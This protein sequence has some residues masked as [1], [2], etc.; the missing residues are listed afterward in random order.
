MLATW[1]YLRGQ[2]AVFDRQLLAIAKARSECRLLM[3]IPG[4]GYVSALAFIGA[5]DAPDR[6]ARSRSVGAH[7]GLV[8]KQHQSGDVDRLGEISKCGDAYVRTVLV[9][10]ANS[11]LIR[12]R[13]PS[14]L[15]EWGLALERRSGPKKA[16]TAL[17]RKLAVVMHSVWRSGTPYRAEAAV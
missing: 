2:V 17:A 15:R 12:S 13:K 8:P 9:E 14:R 11:L 7:L 3:S 1:R 5:I 10:A 4:I 16:R 6:F